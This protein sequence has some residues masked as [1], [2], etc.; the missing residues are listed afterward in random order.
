MR[1]GY[2]SPRHLPSQKKSNLLHGAS[3]HEGQRVTCGSQFSPSTMYVL[4]IELKFSGLVASS[5]LPS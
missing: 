2:L 4:S 3:A 1:C 5:K